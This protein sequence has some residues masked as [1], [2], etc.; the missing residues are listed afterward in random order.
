MVE[1]KRQVLSIDISVEKSKKQR[2]NIIQGRRVK[3][4]RRGSSKRS[5]SANNP[6]VRRINQ[7]VSWWING[8]SWFGMNVWKRLGGGGG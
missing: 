5:K 2:E 7:G 4:M 6:V 1:Y 3:H 8:N